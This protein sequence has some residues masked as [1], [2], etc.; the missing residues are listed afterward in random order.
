MEDVLHFS[1]IPR[2]RTRS[3]LVVK[4]CKWDSCLAQTKGWRVPTITGEVNFHP[5]K[6][7]SKAQSSSG[8]QGQQPPSI[9]GWQTRGGS[10]PWWPQPG[11]SPQLSFDLPAFRKR[12][13]CSSSSGFPNPG[14]PT[15]G[16]STR[17]LAC[18]LAEPKIAP[19]RDSKTSESP[20]TSGQVGPGRACLSLPVATAFT[21]EAP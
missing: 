4:V 12:L 20:S 19:L 1:Q 5:L 7:N 17:M 11:V 16:L 2:H 10:R 8:N 6:R 14:A 9:A 3:L 13:L 21:G 18:S 15:P